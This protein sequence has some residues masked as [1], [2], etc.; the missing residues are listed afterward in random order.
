MEC[1]SKSA[2]ANA[3][4]CRRSVAP[5]ISFPRRSAS[6]IAEGMGSPVVRSRDKMRSASGSHAKYS[7]RCEGTS[8]RSAA[9]RVPDACWYF[10]S[11]NALCIACP[12][13]C[14]NVST[15]P[16]ER[17]APALH[18]APPPKLHTSATTG[19]LR[20]AG[21]SRASREHRT[22]KCAAC[23]NLRGRRERSRYTVPRRSPS[24]VRRVSFLASSHHF[25]ASSRGSSSTVTPK[26]RETSAPTPRM[27]DSRGKKRATAEASTPHVAVR[28]R[29][30]AYARSH[31]RSGA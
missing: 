6:I 30:I 9:H 5:N 17:S 22:T 11:D 7:K 29:P 8:T 1:A 23:G 26:T 14:R 24:R 28:A 3:I 31:A 25:S 10:V 15:S 27:V 13:S 12:N 18:P 4:C 20:L 16:W 21:P 19:R 2:S